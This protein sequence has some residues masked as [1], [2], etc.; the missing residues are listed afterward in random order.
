MC[1]KT[2]GKARNFFDV[3]YFFRGPI[4]GFSAYS[5][6][7]IHPVH[8]GAKSVLRNQIFTK[9]KPY[10][11]QNTLCSSDAGRWKTLGVP[12]IIGGDNHIC[13]LKFGYSEKATKICAI[14]LSKGWFDEF[15]TN[16]RG[17]RAPQ[18]EFSNTLHKICQKIDI[19]TIH[20]MHSRSL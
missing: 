5:R 11:R 17:P 20:L 18:V 4:T 14:L 1:Q 9:V 19:S 13:A 16:V 6:K 7:S 8:N 15:E 12:V 2:Y 3:V 10:L